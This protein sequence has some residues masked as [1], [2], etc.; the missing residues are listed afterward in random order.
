MRGSGELLDVDTHAAVGRQVLVVDIDPQGNASTCLGIEPSQRKVGAYHVLLDGIPLD[1]AVVATEIPNLGVVPSTVDLSGAELELIDVERRE[2]RLRDALAG[3]TDHYDY[4]LID[5][6]PALGILT[7]NAL[8]AANA[9]LVPLQCEFL[10][11]EGLSQLVR[12]LE[13]LKAARR[14]RWSI[15]V[16]P[17]DTY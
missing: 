15:D 13:G 5:C 2:Y 11:L 10:A 3:A 17:A 7:I 8:T 1:H 14:V 4:V 16:D 6:P 9:V 12:Q